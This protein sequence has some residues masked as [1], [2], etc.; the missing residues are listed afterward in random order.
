[1]RALPAWLRSPWL[2]LAAVVLMVAEFWLFDAMTSRH[3][4]RSYPRWND[5]IQ[6]LSEA[7]TAFEHAKLHGLASGLRF[8]LSKTALQG[9]LHDTFALPVFWLV[10][11]A[12][13]SAALSLNMLAFLAWQATLLFTVIRLTG[14]R[15]LGWMAF[16]LLLCVAWPWSGEA[17]SAVDFRLDHAA[18]CLMG[19][20]ACL[21][22][23]SDGFRS[24]RWTLAFGAAVGV[25]MLERFL[26]GIYFAGFYLAAAA[27]VL[28]GAD[29]WPRLRNL[30]YAGML[31][32]AL[33]LPVF[34][35][36]RTAI[37]TYYWVGHV[38]GAESA[39]RFRGL[40]LWH[41]VQFIFGNLGRMHLGTYFGWTVLGLTGLL[42][43]LRRFRS[44]P[45]AVP[46]VRGWGF[47]ATAY[48]LVPA[49]IL[50]L[51]KQKSEYVLGVLVPGVMLLVV[52]LWHR[53]AWP[54]AGVPVPGWRRF[55]PALPAVA[56][57]VI[58]GNY[59][60]QRQCRQPHSDEARASFRK[61]NEISDYIFRTARAGQVPNPN[62]TVDQ[63]V[64]FLDAQILQV[65][66]YERHKVWVP[67]VIQ[68]PNS[69]LAEQEDVVFYRMNLCD[70]VVLTENMEGSG[71]WPYDKEMR[72][73]YPRLKAWAD[74]NLHCVGRFSAFQRDM[75]LYQRRS[76]PR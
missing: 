53:L 15:A 46:G 2:W 9:T 25:T 76:L 51:H 27:W 48:L 45:P 75:W 64:D 40:D 44:P 67:F 72:R 22:L 35:L 66:C 31:T 6:Y 42:V 36:N 60:V 43:A 14:S 23:L 19:V 24:T 65:T 50:C 7:Y 61:I 16:G 32:T 5:Q 18:M 10:G 55:L 62:I 13:R 4:T 33:A 12:S 71:Y 34:W 47:I 69:I 1:M 52:W 54:A 73:L 57:L 26:T 8:A 30:L 70:F 49:A 28:A 68:L 21:A 37:Y 38:T 29:R 3:W 58:G 63:V 11:S 74:E 41:S 56:A 17:A 20:T 39:A 59:F